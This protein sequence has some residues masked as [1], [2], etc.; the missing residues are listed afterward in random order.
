MNSLKQKVDLLFSPKY[1]LYTNFALGGTFLAAGDVIEQLLNKK[2]VSKFIH[3][4]D[5]EEKLKEKL[6][7]K[8]VET[9]DLDRVGRFELFDAHH[10]LTIR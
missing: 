4:K 6:K 8:T 2:V 10:F 3:R 9:V 5:S 1:L 7:D